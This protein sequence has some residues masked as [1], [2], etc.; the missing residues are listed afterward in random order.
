[1]TDPRLSAPQSDLLDELRE[2]RNGLYIRRRTR[3]DRTVRSLERLGLVEMD[4]LDIS[5]S[6]QD[7]WVAV[8]GSATPA[9]EET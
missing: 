2:A 6:E 1:M 8:A 4:H 9:Q 3:W 7:H 5:G